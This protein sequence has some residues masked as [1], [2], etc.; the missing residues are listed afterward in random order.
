MSPSDRKRSKSG[1]GAAGSGGYDF[2]ARVLAYVAAHIVGG[3]RLDWFDDQADI[4][5]AGGAGT[6]GPGDDLQLECAKGPVEAQVKRGLDRTGLREVVAR[7]AP[8]L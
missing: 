6:G 3:R 7:F 5:T 1:G 8:W 4:P 2:Q